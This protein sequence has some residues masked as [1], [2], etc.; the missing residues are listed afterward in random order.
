MLPWGDLARSL[1]FYNPGRSG[2]PLLRCAPFP[3][4]CF[5]GLRGHR[6]RDRDTPF[7]APFPG[8]AAR[9]G[10]AS[11]HSP[12]AL[13][14]TSRHMHP[15]HLRRPSPPP[16]ASGAAIRPAEPRHALVQWL[17]STDP[18]ATR[19]TLN[20]ATDRGSTAAPPRAA[21]LTPV[22]GRSQ[23]PGRLPAPRIVFH[24]DGGLGLL[25]PAGTRPAAAPAP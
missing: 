10:A 15:S 11:G 1:G 25:L 6:R 14:P 9:L 3:E 17:H 20:S 4:G 16:A 21:S 23:A 7:G 8:Y 24:S 2:P 5:P 19:W 22:R 13:A 18:M 12:T